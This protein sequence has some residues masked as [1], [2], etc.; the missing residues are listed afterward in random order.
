MTVSA[1]STLQSAYRFAGIFDADD[2]E[3]LAALLS[4]ES[5]L[6]VERRGREIVI[7]RP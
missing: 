3:S 1:C 4:Q 7:R 6:L 5:D 2:P